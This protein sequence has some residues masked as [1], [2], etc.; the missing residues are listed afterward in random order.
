[1]SN[2]ELFL[3]GDA[4]FD[5]GNVEGAFAVFL[6]GAQNGCVLS[7]TRL[8]SMYTSGE[9]IGCNYDKAIEWE[10]EAI[11]QG[12]VSAL[13]NVGI[14]YRIKG[15]IR[16]AKYWFEKS[17]D[18]GDGSGAL[19]LAKLYMVSDKEISTVKKYLNLAI[20]SE[21]MC[22]ADIEEARQ[23]LSQM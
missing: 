2:D 16:K 14:S 8:A 18:A 10:L 17:I 9:G 6:E 19:E 11:N 7:M 3:A 5:E 21:N 12:D 22:E 4:L 15:D 20:V 13:L 1:M 23:L